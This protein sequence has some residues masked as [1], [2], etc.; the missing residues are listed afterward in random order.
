MTS[1]KFGRLVEGGS[2]Q[3]SR[4]HMYEHSPPPPPLLTK[5]YR[6]LVVKSS[7]RPTRR[8]LV[9]DRQSQLRSPAP[10]AM[11][12]AAE[13]ALSPPTSFG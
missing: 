4:L 13:L 12:Y 11:I 3:N 6:D 10:P 2:V 9:L 7:L 1:D 8:P 5:M